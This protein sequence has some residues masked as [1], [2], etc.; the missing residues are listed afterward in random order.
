MAE[1]TVREKAIEE[2]LEKYQLTEEE[3]VKLFKIAKEADDRLKPKEGYT[4]GM[5]TEKTR[6]VAAPSEGAIEEDVV[7]PEEI[8]YNTG[9]TE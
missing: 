2:H 3:Q 7:E 5:I 9:E 4:Y 8:D 1:K 6:Y